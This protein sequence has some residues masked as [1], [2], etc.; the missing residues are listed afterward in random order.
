LTS[1]MLA[2]VQK[3]IAVNQDM[4]LNFHSRDCN[5]QCN[6]Y[7]TMSKFYTT[8]AIKTFSLKKRHPPPPCCFAWKF[9]GKL[10]KFYCYSVVLI[11]IRFWEIFASF[12][13]TNTMKQV[14]KIC[15]W[16]LWTWSAWHTC[17]GWYC[18][19]QLLQPRFSTNLHS[20]PLPF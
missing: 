8:K 1:P 5:S 14:N 19:P 18:N 15:S 12:E 2:I 3:I 7:E 13:I 20:S 17:L 4:S 11:Y 16:I 6:C 9:R 10:K